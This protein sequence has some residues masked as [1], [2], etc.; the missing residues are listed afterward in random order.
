MFLF[1]DHEVGM[2]REKSDFDDGMRKMLDQIY[3]T[4]ITIQD[5]GGNSTE[6]RRREKMNY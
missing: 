3:Q 2:K 6:S 4:L 5:H 1:K